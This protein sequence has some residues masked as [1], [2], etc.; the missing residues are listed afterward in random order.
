MMADDFG[1]DGGS[2]LPPIGSSFGGASGMKYHLEG[3]VPLI[4]VLIIAAV[5]GSYLG[6][7][8]IPF[9]NQPT[10]SKMLIIGEPSLSLQATLDSQAKDMVTYRKRDAQ[11]LRQNPRDVFAEYDIIMLNQSDD[12]TKGVPR[13]V[14]EALSDY[15]RRG[16]KLIVVMNSGI[17]RPG[18]PEIIGWRANFGDLIPVECVRVDQ[19]GTPSCINSVYVAAQITRN[20]YDHPIMEGIEV[21]PL[22][23]AGSA[24]PLETFAVQTAGNANEIAYIQDIQSPATYPGIV[25]KRLIL[26]KVIYFNYDDGLI[27]GLLTNTLKYL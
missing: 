26:G 22:I 18:S 19:F 8:H 6:F 10:Q 14:A 1:D 3:L 23:P 13:T 15:V 7:W 9:I 11:S 4:L 2:S 25:E 5:A 12:L 20:D 24:I 27:P 17:Y 16:G 21:F